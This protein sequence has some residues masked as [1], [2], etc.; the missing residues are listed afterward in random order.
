MTLSDLLEKDLI[1]IKIECASKDEFISKL[2]SRIYDLGRTPPFPSEEVLRKIKM[3]EEIGGTLLPS[4]LAAP[5]A[6]LKD[7]EGFIIAA[8]TPMEPLFFDGIQIRLVSLMIS[9][10]SGGPYY[11]PTLAGL[12]KL[13]R[14]KEYFSKLCG[15]ESPD[16]FIKILKERDP[17]LA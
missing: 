11:L 2:L 7:Y 13:S 3:R 17:E 1:L 16:R 6:R 9:S 5:H 10:Q 4:G 8:G 12:T 15:A 14:D